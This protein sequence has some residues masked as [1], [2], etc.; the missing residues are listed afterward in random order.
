MSRRAGRFALLV[1]APARVGAVVADIRQHY[2]DRVAP[3]GFVAMIVGLIGMALGAL[4]L[5]RSRR[6][7]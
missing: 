6:T 5:A 7:A 1:K 3:E 2:I 4:A